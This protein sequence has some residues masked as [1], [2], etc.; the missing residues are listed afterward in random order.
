MKIV[1]NTAIELFV[2]VLAL[3]MSIPLYLTLINAFKSH[4]QIV[5]A[6]LALPN[7]S[8]GFDNIARAFEKMNTLKAYG[9][10]FSIGGIALIIIIF[11]SAMAAYAV[12]RIRH[13]LFNTL[14]W[15]YASAILIPVQSV[16][17]PIVFILKSLSLQ[18]TIIGITL[19][20]VAVL[21][22]FCI[23]MF[24]GFMRSLPFD[25]EESAYID[26]S[27]PAHTFFR[28]IFPLVKPV[29][30]SLIILQFIYVWNDLQL[31]LVILN[32][33]DHPTISISLYKFFAGRGMADL[34][35]LFGGII[36]TLLPILVLFL[37]FQRFFVKGLSAGAVKG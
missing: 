32:A 29:T 17:I 36:I 13:P 26:G 22:P 3:V 33:N 28:I 35:L 12:A 18:N 1:K 15:V 30:A 9:V 6:P 11:L 5:S 23:F 21:S 4:K 19:V 31:P 14:Y 2:I 8:V 34:S 27:S 20:Y 24:S 10:T 7:F 25:L 37:G 16:L